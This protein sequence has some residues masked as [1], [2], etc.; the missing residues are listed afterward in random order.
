MSKNQHININKLSSCCLS[1][2]LQVLFFRDVLQLSIN[3]GDIG[4]CGVGLVLVRCCGEQGYKIAA[5]P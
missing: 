2:T 1:F 3:E 5:L 4:V